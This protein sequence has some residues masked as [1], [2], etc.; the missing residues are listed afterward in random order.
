MKDQIQS[1]FQSRTQHSQPRYQDW[2]TFLDL[3]TY[4]FILN[5]DAPVYTIYWGA[6]NLKA[7]INSAITTLESLSSLSED[8]IERETTVNE[9]ALEAA[10][11]QL[12]TFGETM[13]DRG[14]N[15]TNSIAP[16]AT[17]NA[18]TG[19]A[20]DSML[21]GV[22]NEVSPEEAKN[23]IVDALDTFR[24]LETLMGTRTATLSGALTTYLGM[25]L[26]GSGLSA[27]SDRADRVIGE[28]Q[29]DAAQ[30]VIA[31]KAA[32]EQLVAIQA[33]V[34]NLS[35]VDSPDLVITFGSGV[36]SGTGTAA[37]VGSGRSGPWDFEA[38][39]SDGIN[40]AIDGVAA[41]LFTTSPATKAVVQTRQAQVYAGVS[42]PGSGLSWP[43]NCQVSADPSPVRMQV[44]VDDG[45]AT[46]TTLPD[47]TLYY[48]AGPFPKTPYVSFDEV[49][50]FL[51]GV[52]GLS[53]TV[54]SAGI[55][56]IERTAAG[57]TKGFRF[58]CDD[59]AASVVFGVCNVLA[60]LALNDSGERYTTPVLIDAAYRGTS[61][62]V[63]ELSTN[64]EP[65]DG[66][67]PSPTYETLIEGTYGYL[68]GASILRVDKID[69]PVP[70]LD[71]VSG[72]TE[73]SSPTYNFK[74]RDVAVGD[75]IEFN[76]TIFTVEGVDETTLT[77]DSAPTF[78]GTYAFKVWPDTSGIQVGDM[79]EVSD[80]SLLFTSLHRIS[81]VADDDITVEDD[82]FQDTVVAEFRVF[83]NSLQL[84]SKALDTT[85]AIQVMATST[86]NVELGFTTSTVRGTVDGWTDPAKDFTSY[87]IL[88]EDLLRVKTDDFVIEVIESFLTVDPEMSNTNSGT[89]QIINPDRESHDDFVT[90]LDSWRGSNLSYWQTL[91]NAAIQLLQGYPHPDVV[92]G[93]QAKVALA[94]TAYRDLLTYIS[95]FSVRRLVEV[96]NLFRILLE[97]GFDRARDLLVTCD[98][99]TFFDLEAEEATYQGAF[100]LETQSFVSTYASADTYIDPRDTELQEYA[101]PDIVSEDL[102]E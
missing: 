100:Q 22:G 84:A 102:G 47:L 38:G 99:E 49:Q 65:V 95:S 37:L 64:L 80:A 5:R 94:L 6:R 101:L 53:V 58:S 18:Q 60:D 26:R 1:L 12:R 35:R 97:G 24:E 62:S 30:G 8:R 59:F 31:L 67:D 70:D 17:F 23:Q 93:F 4:V 45:P 69:E 90:N 11:R 76:A 2:Q 39:V 55:L 9:K 36:A 51:A 87:V 42:A 10:R 74:G 71:V 61:V 88:E 25:N 78:T 21:E 54:P 3:I 28:I 20:I 73:V 79:V 68:P 43:L 13:L 56:Q 77:L 14:V 96:D 82:F 98:F 48:A 19:K 16:L 91:D 44:R 63:D 27:I 85:S 86:A 15:S 57:V 50:A 72:S 29:D 33:S 52:G 40:L 83:R 34:N 81:V 41:P 32:V 75:Q 66:L 92:T 89:Y 7:V 46:V